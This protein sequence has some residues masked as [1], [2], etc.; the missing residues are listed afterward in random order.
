M[1][2]REVYKMTKSPSI[3]PLKSMVGEII[4][5][6]CYLTFEDFNKKDEKTVYIMSIQDTSGNVYAGNS[7]TFKESFLD[8][9]DIMSDGV[10]DDEG[11][12]PFEIKLIQGTS[13]NGRQFITCD[14]V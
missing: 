4:E 7:T 3:Q 1:D 14:L 13:N 12:K 5:V 9:W 6:A 11:V 10:T 8:I 2:K